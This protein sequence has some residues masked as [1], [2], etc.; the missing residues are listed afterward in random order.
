MVFKTRHF[1][2]QNW[3]LPS[4][5]MPKN[6]VSTEASIILSKTLFFDP[7]L[8]DEGKYALRYLLCPLF[9]WSDDL[10]KAKSHKIVALRQASPV[11]TNTAFNSQ[12]MWDGRKKSLEDQVIGPRPMISNDEN[13]MTEQQI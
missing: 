13:A 7:R 9:S 2:L 4:I 6:N 5:P 12:K 11:I 10:P 3:I 1:S 8:N